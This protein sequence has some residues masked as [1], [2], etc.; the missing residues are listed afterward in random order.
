MDAYAGYFYKEKKLKESSSGGAASAIS[1]GIIRQGGI[2]YGACYS[3]DFHSAI[4]GRAETENELQKFKG[5]KYVYVNKVLKRDSETVSVYKDAISELKFGRMILFTGL[6]CDISALKRLA[7]KEAVDLNNL[8]TIELLCDGVTHEIVQ[9]E[10]ISNIEKVYKSKVIAFS[11]RYKEDGWIPLY[12]YAK[13]E[14]GKEHIQP[15]YNSDYGFAFLNYKRKI[16]YDCKFKEHKGDLLVADYWGCRAGMEEYNQNGV[17]LILVQ[18]EKGNTLLSFLNKKHFF[19]KKT[20]IDYALYYNPRYYNAHE[21][22][23]QWDVFDKIIREK[24]LREAVKKC[25]GISVP[26]RFKSKKVDEVILWGAGKCFHQYISLLREMFSVSC[27]IDSNENNWEKEIEYGIICQSPDVLKGKKNIVVL[28]MIQN[29][30]SAFQVANKLLDMGIT[31]FDYIDN[32]LSY[33]D[34]GFT[35]LQ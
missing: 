31:E 32:W 33:A 5:S 23:S 28:I 18:N 15:F 21:R 30:S 29:I 11:V 26:E 2:V 6:G 24:G 10:Y 12:I 14:N 1:E 13:F 19:L 9:A 8:F 4:Y 35:I 16:C 25:A 3:S 17:S 22:Y 20:N 34:E 7:E 27:V